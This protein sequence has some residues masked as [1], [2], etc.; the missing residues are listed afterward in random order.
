VSIDRTRC[1]PVDQREKE[2]RPKALALLSG[3]LDS[4]LAV[5]MILDQGVDVEAVNF[6]TPFCLCDK[7]SVSEFGQKLGIKI[8]RVFLGQEFLDVVADPPYG[9][10]SHM[11]P[12]LDCRI[13]MFKKA[14]GLAERIGADFL[15]TGEVLGERPFSQ[16]KQS[17]LR[18]EKEAGVEGRVLR[19][20]S[21]ALLP[22]SDPEKGGLVKRD[23]LL[24][25]T[26]RRRAPQME[27]ARKMGIEDYPNPSGGCLLTD[28]RFAERL[29]EHLEHEKTLTL[30]DVA[31]LKLGRHFRINGAK[32]IVGRNE[33]E[34][35]RLLMI[36]ERH[37]VPRLEMVDY[38]GPLTLILGNYDLNVLEKAAAITVRYSDAPKDTPA[39][40][41]LKDREEKILETEAMEDEELETLRV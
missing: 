10:G 23:L 22:E 24:G 28:P 37:T 29:R 16:R 27:L 36:A 5:K 14:K 12:C 25:I 17:I 4:L 20:L 3:G 6:A 13:L 30:A 7:C 38:I 35:R 33:E 32:I 40:V 41:I 39:R 9:Y 26:G 21:A 19:P 2:K 11:N 31:L 34:N 8:H 18:I 1:A 15:V